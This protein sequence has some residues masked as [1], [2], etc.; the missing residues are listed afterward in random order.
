MNQ[1]ELREY[2][3]ERIK[4]LPTLPT[5][6]GKVLALT[7]SPDSSPDELVDT[8]S[9]DPA[10]SARI[11]RVANSAY[12][13]F[14]RT[15]TS[16]DRALPLIGLDAISSMA[17]SLGVMDKLKI[18][19]NS[20]AFTPAGLWTHSLAVAMGLELLAKRVELEAHYLFTLGL[21]HD[22]GKIVLVRDFTDL[23][24][25][26]HRQAR[27]QG[28][29]DASIV[30]RKILGFDH[31]E[32][33]SILLSQWHLPELLIKPIQAHHQDKE[34]P[35]ASRVD[36]ALLRVAD[37]VAHRVSLGSG[38]R[39]APT[40]PPEYPEVLLDYLEINDEILDEVEG[41]L[42][43]RAESIEALYQAMA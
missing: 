28:I 25:D 20:A 3:Y 13:G 34:M 10:L 4:S 12:Y 42:A 38:L 35:R 2:L 7:Q 18:P 21:L 37:L 22:V 39:E 6:L 26:C 31:A 11:L 23:Y 36:W 14:P 15:I 19:Q 41:E 1:F 40:P 33:A 16:L 29:W 24:L 43:T 27:E 30:E 5:V 32:V 17:M 9:Q 8:I